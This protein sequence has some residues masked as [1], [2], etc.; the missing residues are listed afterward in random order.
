MSYFSAI[1][2]ADRITFEGNEVTKINT[3]RDRGRDIVTHYQ[4]SVG[5]PEQGAVLRKFS[6]DEIMHLLECELLIVEKGYHSLARQT[7]RALQGTDELFGA[8]KKQRARIV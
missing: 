6:V 4:L 7:D 1:T 2:T 3:I 5:H 8:K